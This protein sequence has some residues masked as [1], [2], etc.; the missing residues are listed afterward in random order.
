M[1]HV[2]ALTSSL[3]SPMISTKSC[4]TWSPTQILRHVKALTS[5][6]ASPMISTKS[7][8]SWSPTQIL[9][10]TCNYRKRGSASYCASVTFV[11][12]RERERRLWRHRY[13]AEI[14]S[15]HA[16]DYL[17]G[18]QTQRVDAFSEPSLHGQGAWRLS[19]GAAGSSDWWMTMGKWKLCVRWSAAVDHPAAFRWHASSKKNRPSWCLSSVSFS[20]GNGSAFENSFDSGYPFAS[21]HARCTK[22]TLLETW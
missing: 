8:R 22:T 3:V 14:A 17:D 18:A 1:W 20:N 6:L 13:H 11:R 19:V 12:G 15:D 9:K 4:R 21:V 2:K 10:Q 7:C 5:S 16:Y